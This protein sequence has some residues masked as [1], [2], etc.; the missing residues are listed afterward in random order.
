M[1]TQKILL[2]IVGLIFITIFFFKVIPIP[3]EERGLQGNDGE[4]NYGGMYWTSGLYE[5]QVGNNLGVRYL[6]SIFLITTGGGYLIN[7]I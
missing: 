2:I 7:K 3:V 4:F 5:L 1:K 6:V